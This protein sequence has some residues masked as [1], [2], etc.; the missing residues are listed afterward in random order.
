MPKTL[1]VGYKSNNAFVTNPIAGP[2]KCFYIGII[3]CIGKCRRRIM[4][5]GF[6][7]SPVEPRIFAVLVVVIFVELPGVVGRVADDDKD[8]GGLLALHPLAV[9]GAKEVK[10]GLW[11]LGQ[12]KGIDQ[13]DAVKGRI[14]AGQLVIAVFNVHGG[15]VVG[16]QHHFVAM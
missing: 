4:D 12:L 1:W 2:A 10:T 15:N 9:F 14:V 8:V 6:V 7:N 13:T 16:Q 5:I 11:L 3:Q